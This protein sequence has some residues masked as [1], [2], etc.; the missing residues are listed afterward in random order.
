[1]CVKKIRIKQDFFEHPPHHR[2]SAPEDFDGRQTDHSIARRSLGTG[3]WVE[4]EA[5]R[6]KISRASSLLKEKK[7]RPD[8]SRIPA[9]S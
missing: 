9:N 3:R 4:A 6:R 8:K 7:K 5:E 1:M 2:S